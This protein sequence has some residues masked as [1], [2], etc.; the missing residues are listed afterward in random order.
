LVE[1]YYWTSGYTS[2]VCEI[3]R[4]HPELGWENI[5]SKTVSNGKITYT[6]NAMGMRSEEVDS[7]KEHILIL[8]DS[9][10]FGLG[11]NN[12]ETVSSYLEKEEQI[13]SLGY[14]VLN[15]GVPGWGIGQY[16]LNLKRHIDNLNPKLIVL[17]IYATTDLDETRKSD[18]YG[19]SK[20][21]FYYQKGSLINLTP[22][23]SKF[24]CINL[25]SRLRFA[26]HLIPLSLIESCKTK[27]IERD[28]AGPTISRLIEEIRML[29][30]QR[31]VPTLIVLSPTLTAVESIRCNQSNPP[32]LCLF[33]DSGF[34]AFYSYFLELVNHY[35]YPHIDFI[36]RLVDYNKEGSVKSLYVNNGKDPHHYSSQGNTILS[37]AIADRLTA[38]FD[39]DNA[40]PFQID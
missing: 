22:T 7:S 17:I 40:R 26:K 39:M 18:R 38:D 37:Q 19:I 20:P 1:G 33:Y 30:M 25:Y 21:M 11:V 32:E 3:C 35:N 8:G 36:Q 5:P 34:E 23:I 12:D 15:L 31:N 28:K 24:S 13:S 6:T 4:F 2:L 16:Y 27:L 10:V 29:G 9:V 14:Q